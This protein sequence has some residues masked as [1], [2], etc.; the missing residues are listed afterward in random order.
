MKK[1]N[2]T[3]ETQILDRLAWMLRMKYLLYSEG[4]E[5]PEGD[6]RKD[7]AGQGYADC[8][9]DVAD[10]FDRYGGEDCR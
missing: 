10:L 4:E 9:F 8:M 3:I 5:N 1:L 2:R 6:I 7:L